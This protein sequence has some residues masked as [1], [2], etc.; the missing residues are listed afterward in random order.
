MKYLNKS[1]VFNAKVRDVVNLYGKTKIS[2][3]IDSARFIAMNLI[4]FL[5][6]KYLYRFLIYGHIW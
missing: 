4:Q 2:E 6:F 1:Q 5:H 3:Q